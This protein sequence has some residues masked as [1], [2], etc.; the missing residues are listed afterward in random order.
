V[1]E[2]GYTD[3]EINMDIHLEGNQVKVEN[4]TLP[5]ARYKGNR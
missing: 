1:P 2:G 5:I 4:S 3:L